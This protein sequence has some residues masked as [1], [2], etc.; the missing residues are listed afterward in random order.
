MTGSAKNQRNRFSTFKKGGKGLRFHR[1]CAWYHLCTAGMASILPSR[2]HGRYK[3]LLP[4]K[5]H[6]FLLN[7]E[8]CSAEQRKYL[9]KR[10]A[11]SSLTGCYSAK[12]FL[13]EVQALTEQTVH[14]VSKAAHQCQEARSQLAAQTGR[15][16]KWGKQPGLYWGTSRMRVTHGSSARSPTRP[17]PSPPK[18]H[19]GCWKNCLKQPLSSSAW[20]PSKHTQQPSS[21]IQGQGAP[22]HQAQ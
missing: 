10:R 14:H 4:C 12:P 11:S 15:S 18:G 20:I 5:R 16:S 1:N 13:E 2:S 21:T 19:G 6:I 3:F 22:C 8:H 7:A 17:A 9:W